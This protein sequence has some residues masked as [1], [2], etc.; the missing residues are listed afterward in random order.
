MK[1][2]KKI[3]VVLLLMVCLLFAGCDSVG[4]VGLVQ[5]AD[6]TVTEF[7]IIPYAE[8][9]M[10]NFGLTAEESK[11][12]KAKAKTALD[13]AIEGYIDAYK[14]RIDANENYTN[15]E[16]EYLKGGVTTSNSFINKTEQNFTFDLGTGTATPNDYITYIRYELYFKDSTCYKEFKNANDVINEDK[17]IITERHLFTTTTKV[18]KDPLFDKMRDETLTLSNYMVGV[19]RDTVIDV[20][21]GENPTEDKLQQ[22]QE[23]WNTIK[24]GVD[25][26]GKS[27]S[28]IYW[29]VV[30]TARLKSNAQ[31]VKYQDGYYWHGWQI[32]SNNSSMT[33]DNIKF[34]YWTTTANK[35]VWYGFAVIGAI[36]IMLITFI[37]AKKQE[38]KEIDSVIDITDTTNNNQTT[39]KTKIDPT[40]L[41]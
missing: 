31:T 27:S 14:A 15:A 40:K 24:L 36:V 39:N 10:I 23:R 37:K 21:A 30:P 26:E 20:L 8:Q 19:I 12:I 28:F 3:L 41:R 16:K 9:E 5:N 25:F 4:T 1:K 11:T 33:G 32:S 17:E 2:Y 18:V 22:A 6:G 38:K 7:Y 34:E 29:Y 13:S 35:A